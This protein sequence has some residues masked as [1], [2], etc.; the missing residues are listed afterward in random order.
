MTKERFGRE[1]VYPGDSIIFEGYGTPVIHADPLP[2]GNDNSRAE[3][4]L[5][6][7]GNCPFCPFL[8]GFPTCHT[9]SALASDEACAVGATQGRPIVGYPNKD[10]LS[11]S[12]WVSGSGPSNLYCPKGRAS[13]ATAFP[14]QIE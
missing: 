13:I 1:H 10:G 14:I 9:A 3:F 8:P 6:R 12:C 11:L 5:Q 2:S 4:P 7:T